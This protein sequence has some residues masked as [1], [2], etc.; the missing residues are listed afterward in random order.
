MGINTVPVA[1]PITTSNADGSPNADGAIKRYVP[2]RMKVGGHEETINLLVTKLSSNKVFL[3]HEW[4]SLHDP[5]ISWRKKTLHFTRCPPTCASHLSTNSLNSH[6]DYFTEFPQVFSS[7]EFQS[8]PP[9]RPWD[10]CIDLSDEHREINEKLYSL[11][12]EE[13][14]Q[15]D[16]W[17]DENLHSGRIQLSTSRYA[18]PCFFCH[19]PKTQLC[20]DYQKLNA[21]TIKDRY[22]LPRIW[23]L[24]DRLQG[25]KYFPRWMFDGDLTMSK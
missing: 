9:H 11:T 13:R 16:K 20:H 10:H 22:P 7:E 19:D 18:S 24:I 2:F 21:I 25:A 3:G 17:L 1:K 5:E 23:D 8:L 12:Q 4:L 6:P 14:A 15:L